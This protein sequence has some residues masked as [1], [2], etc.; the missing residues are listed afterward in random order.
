V[1]DSV[2]IY[3]SIIY[4][5]YILFIWVSTSFRSATGGT[6]LSIG[7][8]SLP[9]RRKSRDCSQKG[10]TIPI[11]LTKTSSYYHVPS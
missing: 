5:G 4:A 10:R 8:R 3:H 11:S 2:Y 6:E 7:P 9:S 1:I